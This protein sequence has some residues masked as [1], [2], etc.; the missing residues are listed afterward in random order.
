M[1]YLLN[2]SCLLILPSSCFA[3]NK[4]VTQTEN[5]LNQENE[6]YI[7]LIIGISP[8]VGLI[9]FEYQKGHNAF[10]VGG[11]F[12]RISYRYYYKPYSD[13]KFWGMY[14][15]RFHPGRRDTNKSYTLNGVTYSDV[16][17][18]VIGV[19]IGYRWQWSSGWN[20]SASIALEYYDDKYSDSTTSQTDTN[21]GF[22]PFPGLNIGYK[23]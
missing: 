13:T 2:A 10:G 9:G 6:P 14:L 22:D 11:L 19:G 18:T 5:I 4:I 21:T 17:T 1:K 23:F 7:N 16:E 12:S 20:A 8:F 15:G 3:E